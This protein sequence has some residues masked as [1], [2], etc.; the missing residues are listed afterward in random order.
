MKAKALPETEDER[1]EIISEMKKILK[2]QKITNITKS[3]TH[4]LLINNLILQ[5]FT[6]LIQ[7]QIQRKVETIEVYNFELQEEN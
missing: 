7:I 6:S 1:I 5:I 4:N 2:T 3:R